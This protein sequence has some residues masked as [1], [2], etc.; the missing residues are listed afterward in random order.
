M[1]SQ[2]CN[3]PTAP[4]TFRPAHTPTKQQSAKQYDQYRGSAAERGY[5][6][7]WSKYSKW[8][9]S[10]PECIMAGCAECGHWMQGRMVTD[11]IEPCEPTDERF[12]QAS[13][14]QPMCSA[15]NTAK[16]KTLDVA[17]KQG[18]L[19][20]EQRVKLERMKVVAVERAKAIEA[21]QCGL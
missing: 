19:T 18:T 14:H 7:T 9:L 15:H 1:G 13:N 16:G 21:R 20:S 3:I 11:H 12:M 10:Q 4:K 2:R 17:S 8:F 5:T 6:K